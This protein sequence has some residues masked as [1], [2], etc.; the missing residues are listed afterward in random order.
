MTDHTIYLNFAIIA[1]IILIYS[2]VAGRLERGPISGPIIFM[3]IGLILGPFVFK[4]LNIVFVI[5]R[6]KILA[7]FAL[8]LVLFT[9]AAKTNLKVLKKN[10]SIPSRLL[11]LGL[12]LSIIF[13][14]VFGRWIFPDF[15]WIEIAILATIL[16]PTDAALGEPVVSNPKVPT[17]LREGIN[18]ESGLNDGICVPILVL[19]MALNSVQSDDQITLAY[20]LSVF[21]KEIGLGLLVGVGFAFIS[22]L[23]IKY[24]ITNHWI[25]G[26]WKPVIITLLAIGTFALA[27]TVGGSGFIACFSGGLYFGSQYHKSK[28]VLLVSSEGIGKIFTAIVWLVFGS[29]IIV[30]LYDSI[31]LQIVLYAL[32]SLTV[33]RIIPVL[34][35]LIHSK[36]SVYGKIFTAWFGPRGLASIVFTTILF[37]E[38]IENSETIA[39][40]A[41]CTILF[42]VI[43][44][45]ISATPMAK[46]F[47]NENKE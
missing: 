38:Q 47:G 30:W 32:A 19:L 36:I 16:A 40:V 1:F 34:I 26:S 45:G 18:V 33:I 35:S 3:T 15:S 14:I 13:G 46:A 7:E 24:G 20:G 22:N 10:I 4:A 42:S 43:A 6:Y 12:P 28:S 29:V 31:T 25:E 41:C 17:N 27:Q 23:S 11:L 8:A 2:V 39:L 5:E 44:H 37:K 9:D 21:A